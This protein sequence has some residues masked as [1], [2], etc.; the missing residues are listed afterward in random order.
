MQKET[1]IEAYKDIKEDGTELTQR[2]RIL[3]HIKRTEGLTRAEIS[4]QL[5]IPINAVTGRC[6]KLLELGLVIESGTRI[7]R[8]SGKKNLVL[9]RR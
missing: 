5:N 3:E 9:V 4:E 7:N 2:D 8:Y 1:S 6:N